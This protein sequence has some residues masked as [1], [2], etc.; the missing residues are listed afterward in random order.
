MRFFRTVAVCA[1]VLAAGVAACSSLD[2]LSATPEPNDAG[3]D[4]S[5]SSDASSSADASSDAPLSDAAV[6]AS[7]KGCKGI[8]ADFCIDFDDGVFPGNWIPKLNGTGA[9]SFDDMLFYSPPRALVSASNGVSGENG[10]GI[11]RPLGPNPDIVFVQAR[12][13]VATGDVKSNYDVIGLSFRNQAATADYYLD[14]EI[15]NALD[16][17]IQQLE[18]P[19]DGGAALSSTRDAV[20]LTLT[21]N[22]W[23]LLTLKYD[24]AQ[25]KATVEVAYDD[26]PKSSKSLDIRGATYGTEGQLIVGDDRLQDGANWR[27]YLDDVAVD[28]TP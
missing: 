24:V 10:A 26:A 4:A 2:G 21:P 8:T 23:A 16:L 27:V 25:A 22:K 19:T 20:G 3:A 12:V 1:A 9:F 13:R 17:H 11:A 15:D 5:P 7:A 18:Y 28:V 14:V 6:D